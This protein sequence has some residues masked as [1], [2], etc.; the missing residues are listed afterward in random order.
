MKNKFVVLFASAPGSSKTPIAYYLSNK[1]D[2]PIHNNDAIRTEVTENLMAFNQKEYEKRRDQRLGEIFRKG[3]PFIFDASIDREWSN[4]K[5]LIEES[6]HKVFIISIDL[7]KEF[8]IKLFKAKNYEAVDK[9]GG[10]IKDHQDFLVQYN[11]IVNLHITDENFKERL[12]LS[13]QK[14]EEWIKI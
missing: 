4:Y 9:L 3:N 7:S 13:A 12:R 8:L 14:L 10:W 5:K 1:F 11:T 2:L 6:D